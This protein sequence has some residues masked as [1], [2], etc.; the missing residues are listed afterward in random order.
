MNK[1]HSMGVPRWLKEKKFEGPTLVDATDA[2][3][4]GSKYA[5]IED[6]GDAK[7]VY[8]KSIRCWGRISTTA[9]KVHYDSTYQT[10]IS[11]LAHIFCK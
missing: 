5:G 4:T 1:R 10:D 3:Y 9:E 8:W 11:K 2:V 7:A 6:S